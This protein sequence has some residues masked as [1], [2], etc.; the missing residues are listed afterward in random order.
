ME[1]LVVDDHS[2]DRTVLIIEKFISEHLQ[3]NIRLLHL[4]DHKTFSK[5]EAI[6]VAMVGM[7]VIRKK[8]S[9]TY[10]IESR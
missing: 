6:R 2:D 10:I 4:S 1:M 5:K 8:V 3:F 9:E 7:T